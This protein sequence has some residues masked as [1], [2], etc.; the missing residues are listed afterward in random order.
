VNVVEL[1][2]DFP[3]LT[4][5]VRLIAAYEGARTHAT[6]HREYGERIGRKLAQLVE[7]GLR[8]PVFEYHAA[9]WRGSQK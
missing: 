1:P 7:E 3:Q 6:R 2:L 9:R 5:T 8:I 4:G